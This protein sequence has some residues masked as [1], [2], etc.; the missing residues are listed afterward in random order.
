LDVV[1]REDQCR[2]LIGNATDNISMLQRLA[3]S[4]PRRDK[5]EHGDIQIKPL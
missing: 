4:Q 1:F 2:I 3:L 5:T